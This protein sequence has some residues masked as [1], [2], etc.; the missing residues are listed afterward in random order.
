MIK[1]C[2]LLQI[3][4]P[5]LQNRKLLTQVLATCCKFRTACRFDL[6][7]FQQLAASLQISSCSKFA[8]CSQTWCNMMKSTGL[9]QLVGKLHRTGKIHNLHRFL[10]VYT[11]ILPSR[12]QVQQKSNVNIV[13]SVW[14]TILI[15]KV[16][17][18]ESSWE[19]PRLMKRKKPMANFHYG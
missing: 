8:W 14:S 10:T 11:S 12:A 9:I 13:S 15:K 19:S 6:S 17:M 7:S 1:I 3:F 4:L 2:A 5:I 18:N 16:E